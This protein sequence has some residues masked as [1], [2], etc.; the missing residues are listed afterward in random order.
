MYTADQRIFI[1]E[2]YIQKRTC[3]KC[4]ERF[5]CKYPDSPVRTKDCMSKLIKKWQTIGSMYEKTV[6]TGKKLEGICVQLQISPQKSLRQLSQETDVSV[7]FVSK[8]IN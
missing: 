3:V 8:E 5:I 2:T 6:L 1:V 4:R 7:V